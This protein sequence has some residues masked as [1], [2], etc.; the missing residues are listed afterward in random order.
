MVNLV[1]A[2]GELNVAEAMPHRVREI[3]HQWIA[4]PAASSARPAS[5]WHPASPLVRKPRAGSGSASP[6]RRI[7]LHA[8]WIGWNP[9]SPSVMALKFGTLS[10]PSFGG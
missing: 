7:F 6:S 10:V 2:G 4:M 3:E 9:F 5:V 8:P 1:A